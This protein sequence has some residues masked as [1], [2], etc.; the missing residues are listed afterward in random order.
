MDKQVLTPSLFVLFVQYEYFIL[1][2]LICVAYIVLDMV[3]NMEV[4]MV[5][6]MEVDMV[7]DMEVDKVV[8]KVTDMVADMATDKKE[9][10]WGMQK[11]KKNGHAISRQKIQ[12][13]ERVGNRGW[14]IGP[15]LF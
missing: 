9:E 1:Y 15:K 3:A 7:A 13:G 2:S 4:N 5:A 11:K 10:K 6:D 12:F 14:L 8:D